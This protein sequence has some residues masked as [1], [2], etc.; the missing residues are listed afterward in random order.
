MNHVLQSSS[1]RELK[2]AVVEAASNGAARPDVL[3]LGK[4]IAFSTQDLES[5]ATSNWDPVV[6]DAMVVAAVVEYCDRSLKRLSASWARNFKIKVPVHDPDR[7]NQPEVY[8]ALHDAL[9]FLTGD[10]WHFAFSQRKEIEPPPRQGSLEIPPRTEATLAFSDGMDSRAVAG[11]VRA[12]L[13]H[14]LV[15]VRLGSKRS[16]KPPKGQPFTAVPY[17]LKKKAHNQ[18]TSAR[19]R[20]FRFALVSGLAS[21][22]CGA[23]RIIIP[24]SGQGA[25]GPVLAPVAHAYP[26]YRNHP[27]FLRRMQRF[28]NALLGVDIAYSFPRLWYTKGQ[29]LRAYLALGIDRDEWKTTRSCW[30]TAQWSSVDGQFRQCG[31]CAA[32]M[33]RRLSVHAAGQAEPDETYI[34]HDL[35]AAD[36]AQSVP[37]SFD[38]MNDAFREYAIAG[39]LHMDH[40]ADLAKEDGRAGLRR[41]AF[42]IAD[43]QGLSVERTEQKIKEMISQHA[44][45]WS[46]FTASL[47]SESFIHN[48]VRGGR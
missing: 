6:F 41:Q 2:V 42:E 14:A 9:G 39:V 20:G 1:I 36:L 37:A 33:L 38:K 31:V 3:V 44:D 48:W 4:D 26:D 35:K 17:K 7:W 11:L 27:A 32:C 43:T 29:T 46:A 5:Y 34:A 22:I 23:S 15:R 45:E 19:N 40:L 12:D 21:Y 30:K 18:E 24:E 16:D 8:D 10:S 25:L 28:L 13:G 47:G